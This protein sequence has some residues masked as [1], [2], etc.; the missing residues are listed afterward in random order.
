[1]PVPSAAAIIPNVAAFNDALGV[2]A[3]CLYE[4][5]ETKE[6]SSSSFD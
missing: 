3:G 6:E 4:E 1:M 5:L 2:E